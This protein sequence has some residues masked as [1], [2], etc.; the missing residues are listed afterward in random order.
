VDAADR[1]LP[2]PADP[3]PPRPFLSPDRTPGPRDTLGF[4][5]GRDELGPRAEPPLPAERAL[6]PSGE[7]VS[8][9]SPARAPPD[10]FEEFEPRPPV[11]NLPLRAFN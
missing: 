11:P 2:S 9:P 10:R 1:E 4:E 8:R 7:R 5:D 3:L 6:K